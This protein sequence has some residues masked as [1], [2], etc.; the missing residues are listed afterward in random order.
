MSIK[1]IDVVPV[2]VND[3]DKA[4]EFYV[5]KLGMET[6]RDDPMGPDARWVQVKP[7]WAETSVVFVKGFADWTPEKVGGLQSITLWSENAEATVEELRA[8]GVEV[9]Q[10]P[11]H[12]PWGMVE[13]RFKDQDGNEFLLYGPTRN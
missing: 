13:V 12:Q 6:V 5:N 3:Q 10:E 8:Q 4:V 11:T 2:Y 1:R 7:K 9:S